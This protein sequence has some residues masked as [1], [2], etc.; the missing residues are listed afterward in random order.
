[1]TTLQHL[2]KIGCPQLNGRTTQVASAQKFTPVW[3]DL[4]IDPP[5]ETP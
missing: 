4:K 1:M 5:V 3:L 2:N